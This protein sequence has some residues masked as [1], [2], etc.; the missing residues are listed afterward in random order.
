[1][2]YIV[3]QTL[4]LKNNK[5]YIGVHK[6]LNPEVFDGYVGCGI[7][8]TN[9]STYMNP[10]TPLQYAVKKYGTSNFRRTVLYTFDTVQ[11]A[12]EKEIEL[13]NQE[14]I[15]RKDTYNA[16]IGGIGGSSY[17]VK[18][19][20][21]S[22]DGTF[23]KEWNSI[24]E[25]ADFYGISSTSI[26]R[27]VSYKG[28][29]INYFWSKDDTIKTE[30][31]THATGQVVY[32]YNKY[33]KFEDMFNSYQEAA[34]EIGVGP[35][36]IKRAVDSGYCVK[37]CNY[38]RE[39]W[40]T[41]EK[42]PKVTLK[43]KT[44]YVYTLKGEFVTELKTIP[45]MLEYFNIKTTHSIISVLRSGLQYKTYQL[46]LEKHDSLPEIIDRRSIKKPIIQYDLVGNLIKEYNTTS[47]AVK[48]YGTGVTAVLKGQQQQ[49]KGFIFRYKS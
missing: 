43:N 16:K 34:T 35:S 48:I 27:A 21:F 30:E 6:T 20:Q 46:S 25:A 1:M 37:E 26:N 47:E 38:S 17:S 32:K 22:L 42:R 28:S 9:P 11:E 15:N 12:F 18:I 40:E 31:F 33:G 39:L 41:F 3:Y 2:K 14:F 29:S 5:I 19:K 10:K 44:L 45:E 4:N 8:I 49:C 23:L 36:S 24:Q 7:I 13:V